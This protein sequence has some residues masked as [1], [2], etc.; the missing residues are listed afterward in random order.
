VFPTVCSYLKNVKTVR[1]RE[2]R[3]VLAVDWEK[4]SAFYWSGSRLWCAEVPRLTDQLHIQCLDVRWLFGQWREVSLAVRGPTVGAASHFCP[5][6]FSALGSVSALHYCRFP[7][8]CLAAA[9]LRKWTQL[10]YILLDRT[11]F[12]IGSAILGITFNF[13]T[14]HGSKVYR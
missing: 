1:V 14:T 3:C 13:K 9:L 6:G 2:R 8:F 10:N 7:S 12:D 5:E 11:C 4:S